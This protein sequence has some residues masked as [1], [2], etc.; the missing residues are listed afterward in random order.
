IANDSFG[1]MFDISTREILGKDI[2]AAS[3]EHIIKADD[4]KRGEKVSHTKFNVN[5]KTISASIAPVA[6]T[7]DSTGGMVTVFRDFTRE[8]QLN[9]MKDSFV[10]MA[11]HELRTPLNAIIGY[12]DM[13]LQGVYGD[14]SEDQNHI[15]D[16]VMAN[17]KRMLSMVNNMLDQASF[18]EGRLSLHIAPFDISD[19]VNE[20][21]VVLSVLARG[22]GLE[23]ACTAAENFPP[24][25]MGDHER[26]LQILINLGG[27]AIKFT[28]QGSVKI[29][30]AQAGDKHWQ[31]QVKDTGNGIS[32]ADQKR[33]FEPFEQVG[34]TYTREQGGT[35]LGLSIVKTLVELMGG[36]ISLKS[37]PGE[38]STF[39]IQLP[40]QVIE[41]EVNQA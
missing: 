6:L 34:D 25:V 13:L 41:K 12:S 18:V 2:A 29:D 8:E 10:S 20:A 38:G 30:I 23:F 31:L 5:G 4:L 15:T 36:E 35:G 3:L 28:Q 32:K 16:R 24:S 17:S 1:D 21:D 14:L 39:T 26:L 37:K 22:K 19:L 11:S 40:L 9:R 27:N 7:L 33:I